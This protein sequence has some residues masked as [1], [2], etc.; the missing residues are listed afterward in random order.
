[1]RQTEGAIV[2]P[3][4]GRLVE[5]DD[6]S[7]P[8][9]GRWQPGLFGYGPMLRSIVGDINVTNAI[10]YFCVFLYVVSLA[11]DPRAIFEGRSILGFLSP[12][13]S[14]SARMGMTGHQYIF[15]FDHWYTLLTAVFLHGGIIHIFFNMYWTRNLGPITE[16]CYGPVRFWIL[17]ALSGAGGFLASA[18][19]GTNNTLGASGA[20]MGLLGANFAYARY[21]GG[22]LAESLGQQS[23]YYA[24]MFLLMG[25]LMPGVDN[26]A[27]F[28][29]LVS[30]YLLAQTM[31]PSS[32][33]PASPA[34]QVLAG[35]LAAGVLVGIVAS[36]ITVPQYLG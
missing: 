23:L 5:L 21:R 30:G 19:M 32:H 3:G 18:L 31:L 1:M 20:I 27:H 4:C 29:G 33:R 26:M 13:F 35:L 8:H 15:R 24:G 14:A 16:D 6:A 11:L 28:G 9:C 25:F 2:C 34:L 12:G 10:V 7:C 17:F 22:G 36:L